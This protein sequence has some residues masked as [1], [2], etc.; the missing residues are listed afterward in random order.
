MN[1]L[2]LKRKA[3]GWMAREDSPDSDSGTSY[4]GPMSRDWDG[5]GATGL[6]SGETPSFD[7]A[8]N[9]IDT[10]PAD[11]GPVGPPA[12]AAPAESPAP[13]S[14]EVGGWAKAAQDAVNASLTS[15]DA[16]SLDA[17]TPVANEPTE[18]LSQRLN[19]ADIGVQKHGLNGQTTMSGVENAD[20]TP[21]YSIEA[22]PKDF[23]PGFQTTPGLN[24]N[25]D[26]KSM[27][28]SLDGLSVNGLTQNQIDAF[29]QMTPQDQ[30]RMNG[31]LG[32]PNT[33]NYS[34][35][36]VNP[37]F[38]EGLTDMTNPTGQNVISTYMRDLGMRGVGTTADAVDAQESVNPNMVDRKHAAWDKTMGFVADVVTPIPM[39]LAIAAIKA[40]NAENPTEAAGNLAK[41]IGKQVVGSKINNA[42]GAAIP[43]MNTFNLAASVVNGLTGAGIPSV[44][45]GGMVANAVFGNTPKAVDSRTGN[46]ATNPDGTTKSPSLSVGGWSSSGGGGNSSGVS[47]EATAPA[48]APAPTSTAPRSLSTNMGFN[49]LGAAAG[50]SLRAGITARN[51]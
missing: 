8:G 9:Q 18:S 35:N 30:Q 7:A 25:V 43:G 21:N 45:P 40:F 1:I 16:F 5:T 33:D 19:L 26:P 13:P 32:L 20:G 4:S 14:F 37:G 23:T 39:K 47:P 31:L 49:L 51:Q 46:V 50:K 42:F 17:K 3:Q 29:G 28:V 2:D 27:Q 15:T 44:N 12:S 41:D 34:Y 6:E 11:E 48:P 24:V 22:A 38:K 36:H 10:A